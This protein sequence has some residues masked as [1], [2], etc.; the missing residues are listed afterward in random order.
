MYFQFP[1]EKCSKKLKVRDENVGKK[2]RCPYC[3]HTMLVKKPETPIIDTSIDV[4][5][6]SSTSSS[7][8]SGSSSR[9]GNKN[10]SSG[11]ADGTEVSLSKSG[12]IAVGASVAFIAI[13]FPFRKFY[14]GELFLDRGWVPF[15]LVFLMSWSATILILKYR[16]LGKQKD[17]M[18]F[19]T[20][21][22]D[23]SED[24]SEKTVARF[25]DHV[26]NL[27]VDPRESF[28]VNRVLR[29]LEHFSVLKSSS[30]VSSRL[31][32]QS[33]IDATAVDSSYTI[34]KVFI[35]AIPILG[36]IG[37]VIGISAAV[38]GFS[39][40]MDNATDISALK[41]SLGSVTG[42][43]STA[44]DT[45][46]VAL[47]MSMLVMFPSSSMQKSEEDLL[48]W[49][50]EYCNENL[51]KRLKEPDHG[52]GGGDEKDHR[53]L[54]QKTIDKAMA[55]HHA[56]LQTWIEKLEGIGDTLSQQVV[57][58]WGKIDDKIREQQEAQL[59]EV[60]QVMKHLE[61][62]EE[63]MTALQSA[64]TS[65]LEKM[66]GEATEMTEAAGALSQSF[67]GVQQGLNGLNTVLTNLGEKQVLIQQVEAPRKRWGL[68]G[69][70]KRV[71]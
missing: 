50:D 34:L 17:S 49:V 4:N 21:P 47:V 16:K 24:I 41:E 55:N 8:S 60:Q 40:G 42:G 70:S 35:W 61:S 48:N 30:E 10:V 29:G 27:P 5:T 13:M 28:L 63:K 69:N 1:C 19:D 2:V 33:E 7:R 12:L 45:T 71:R 43:L 9:S 59:A 62:V 36:F 56:E 11:W 32:S 15:A 58:S 22:T 57:K 6:S 46:L 44:F 23:I 51:L 14:L 3:H 18:L 68:F 39:G 20:L 52:G 37:T 31:Q 38:G 65:H 67:N 26:K 53:R 66:N 64:H 54:I 25:I